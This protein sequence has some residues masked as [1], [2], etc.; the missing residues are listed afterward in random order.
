MSRKPCGCPGE[1]RRPSQKFGRPY[2]MF[3]SGRETLLDVP[4]GWE[5][6]PDVWEALMAVREC[7][8]AFQN[9]REWSG[10]YPI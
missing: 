10:I 1:V 4:Q 3:G 7:S 9:V 6:L 2:R 8:E 5:A